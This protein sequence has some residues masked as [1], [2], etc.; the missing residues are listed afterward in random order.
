MEQNKARD[1]ENRGKDSLAKLDKINQGLV[2]KM[3]AKS[4]AAD[5]AAQLLV[6]KA[7][8]NSSVLYNR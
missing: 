8:F 1:L 2:L 4:A 6:D 7:A 3:E 5:Q